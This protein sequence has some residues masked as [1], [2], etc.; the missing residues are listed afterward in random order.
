VT[1]A[2]PFT[3]RDLLPPRARLAARLLDAATGLASLQQMYGMAAGADDFAAS[4]L[5]TLQIGVACADGD[6][7][8]VPATGPLVIVANH[9]HGGADG[10]AVL[11]AIRKIRRDVKLLGND[12]LWRIPEMREHLVA[13]DVFRP[14]AGR[15]AAALRTAV[16]WVRQGHALVVFPAGE[17][18]HVR[19]SHDRVL[20]PTWR[21]GATRIATQAGSPLLPVF[22]EGRNSRL[23]IQLSGPLCS[24]GNCCGFAENLCGFT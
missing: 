20:D 8:R 14:R 7:Q 16:D 17:V 5:Q 13:V 9:P 10:L 19:S 6:L 18:S 3:T 4:A 2:A 11:A 22:I 24:R 1:P 21:D 12:L 23:F 15:N